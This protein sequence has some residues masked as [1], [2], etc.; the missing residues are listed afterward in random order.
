MEVAATPL[1]PGFDRPR[2]LPRVTTLRIAALLAVVALAVRAIGIGMRPLWLDEAYSWWFSARDLQYLWTVVPTYEPHPP[3][4]YTLLKGWRTLFGGSLIGLRSFS[5]VCGVATIPV[6]VVAALELER[7]SPSG[8]E[9]LTVTAAGLLAALSPMLVLLDQEARPYPLLIL[10]FAIAVLGALRLL[11]ELKSGPGQWAS[12]LLLTGGAELAM[13]AH[14]LGLLYAA[15][16]ALAVAPAWLARPVGS[17]RLVRGLLAAA[18]VALLYIPCLLMIVGRSGDWGTGWLSWRPFM[19]LE[20]I[21]LYSVPFEL[22]TVASAVSALIMLLLIKRSAVFVAAQKGWTAERALVLLCLGPPLL[23]ALISV[24]GMPI[25]LT[26]TLAGTLIPAYLL[27]AAAIARTDSPAERRVLVP[28]LAITLLPATLQVALRPATEDWPAVRAYLALHASPGDEVWLYPNDS[29]LPLS[30]DGP[31]LR[32]IRGIPGDYPATD[33]RGP[34]RAGSPAVVSLTHDQAEEMALDPSLA[35]TRTI[36]LVTRQ[37]GVFDPHGDV[38]GALAQ[39]RRAGPK[40]E[41]G[42]IAVQPFTRR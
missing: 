14:G 5:V 24:A 32:S 41:W 42:Y 6:I 30:A 12:W 8:R 28:A 34:I 38:T 39:V 35:G 15:C 21:A 7:Q 23:A 10:A 36:W 25:F 27:M 40:H 29:A 37:P 1:S 13:W 16:L 31:L 18:V 4:Y 2:R 11:R 19:L 3:F 22:L 17:E 20:L 26:R 33:K 9:K